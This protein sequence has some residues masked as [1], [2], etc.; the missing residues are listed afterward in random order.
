MSNY[1]PRLTVSGRVSA[2]QTDIHAFIMTV[3]QIIRG[4]T[5]QARLTIR[6]V[7][8]LNPM[9]PRPSRRLPTVNS[10][11]AFS[12]DILAVEENVTI[13]ALDDIANLPR[14]VNR[15]LP[16]HVPP[17]PQNNMEAVD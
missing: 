12:G 14:H 17:L 11:V 4:A 1:P 5:P 7:M 9:W 16:A 2:V 10:T 8:G 3:W 6:G 13:V 15:P